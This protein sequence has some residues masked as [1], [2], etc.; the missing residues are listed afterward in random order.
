MLDDDP[1]AAVDEALAR[2]RHSPE[3]LVHQ[4]PDRRHVLHVEV[5]AESLG[6]LID[7]HAAGD[8]QAPGTLLSN[9]RL[10]DIVLVADLADDLLENVFDSDQAR[11]AAVF[12]AHDRNMGPA[13]LKV[14]KLR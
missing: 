7:W 4:P 13:R 2:P 9:L 8:P 3:Q 1:Y 11:R 12:V 5:D 10:L 6:Q 14:A